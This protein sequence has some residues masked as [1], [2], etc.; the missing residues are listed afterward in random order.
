V[1]EALTVNGIHHLKFPVADVERSLRFYTDVFGGRRM[2][3]ADHRDAAGN[4][5][6]YILEMPGWN[7]LLDLRLSAEHARGA[8]RLD[9]V[10]L[11]IADRATIT[12]W[13]AHLDA[14]GVA[15]SGEIVTALA[16]MLVIEDPDGRRIRL[17]TQEKHGPELVGAK[18][19]PWMSL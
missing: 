9:P 5:Y 11:N 2:E 14:L 6:A 18:D 12:G 13:V 7:T 16:F 10:T 4:V 17:Y 3:R 8:V 19:H 15:H 1:D